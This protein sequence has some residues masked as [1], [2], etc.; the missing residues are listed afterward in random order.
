M[1]SFATK[2]KPS[3]QFQ[4]IPQIIKA[5]EDFIY[6]ETSNLSGQIVVNVGKIDNRITLPKCPELEP[7]IPTGGRLWGKTSIGVR[8]NSQLS[9][10]I[11]VQADIKVMANILHAA[12]PLVRGQPLTAED[13]LLKN[14]NLTRMPE[15]IF[16]DPQQVIGKIPVTN[17]TS[18]QPLRQ[19]MLRAPYIILRGQKVKLQVMG[20]GFSVSSEGQSLADAAEGEIV[21]VRNQSRRIIS[22]IAR[23]DGI[24][25]VQP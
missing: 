23:H 25:E 3:P 22:G 12:R 16:T 7:F 17:L 6:K 20:R 5:V 11:Y 9:W 8:C 4:A 1:Q 15:G 18:G 10:T 19:H 24:I 21:Q 13:I 14:V 2:H